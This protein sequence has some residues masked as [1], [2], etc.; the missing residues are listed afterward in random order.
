[1][2]FTFP[3]SARS[4]IGPLLL[5]AG[6]LASAVARADTPYLGEIRCGLW[7]YAP[8]GWAV[9]A[10]QVL[11]INQNQALF[12]L[13]G[14]NFGGNG[15]TTFA[16]PDLRGRVAIGQG[17]G[18]G[19]SNYS[20]GQ[21]GGSETTTLSSAQMPAH[22]HPVALPGSATEGMAQSP[23]GLAP[24]SQAR[25]TL[26]AA[27]SSPALAM[28]QASVSSAGG[29]QPFVNMQPYLPL[30]CVIALQGIFPSRD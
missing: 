5:G 20:V 16:L 14:T 23:L 11:P 7:S 9:A 28:S 22:S 21:A 12:S 19:L 25:T 1:M 29:G 30:T 26:Y 6:L 17:Q 10:G 15:Q 3:A 24:A 13:L 2:N 4:L 27:P 8:R 18:P